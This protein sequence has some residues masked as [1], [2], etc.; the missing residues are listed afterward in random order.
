MAA[1]HCVGYRLLEGGEDRQARRRSNQ[2]ARSRRL[3]GEWQDGKG[4]GSSVSE[5]AHHTCAPS[6]TLICR[7]QR[8]I[9]DVRGSAKVQQ[10][11]AGGRLARPFLGPHHMR[12]WHQH[13]TYL[14]ALVHTGPSAST[15]ASYLKHS[16][17]ALFNCRKESTEDRIV[18]DDK[19]E[20]PT[21]K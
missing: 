1:S 20:H 18:A 11:S 13:D 19:L 10:G 5:R 8:S 17:A 9:T 2:K 16:I 12:S 7:P 4:T 21:R 3:F 15:Y 6:L 14:H